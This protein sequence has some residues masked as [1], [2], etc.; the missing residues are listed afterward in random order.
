MSLNTKMVP[1]AEKI[2]TLERIKTALRQSGRA[3]DADDYEVLKSILMDL[4]ARQ[5]LPRSLPLGEIERRLDAVV[6]SKCRLGYD[7]GQVQ[8]LG[9]LVM[10]HWPT[11]R[12]ALE[13]FGEESAE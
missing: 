4:E 9:N 6:R 7:A 10:K 12:Q 13:Q 5:G 3:A 11:L 1:I 2:A 8:E